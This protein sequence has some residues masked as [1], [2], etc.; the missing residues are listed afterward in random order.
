MKAV[1]FERY[2][3]PDVLELR[4]VDKPVPGDDEVLIKVV[5]TALNAM[6]WRFL[7]ADPIIIRAMNGWLTPS[8]TVPGTDVAGI[9]DAVGKNVTRFRPGDAVFGELGTRLGGMAEYAVASERALV[10]KPEGLSFVDAAAVPM[11]GLTALQGLRDVAAVQPGMKVLVL[12]A[13]GGVGTQAI[14]IA[15]LLGAEVTAVCSTSKMDQARELGADHVID[16]TKEDFSRNGQRYDVI[17]AA[18]GNRTLGDFERVLTPN[19]IFVMAGGS[20]GQMMQTVV[21]GRFKSKA[22]GKRYQSFTA[23]TDVDDLVTLGEMLTTGQ[24]SASVDRCYPLEQGQDAMRYLD[25]GHARGKIVVIV[26][27]AL[28]K[29]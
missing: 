20:T 23:R 22:N 25:A 16:Y 2:G 6:D 7:R 9:V 29:A 18:N 24:L 11:A 4:D 21:L 13:S 8:K 1:V 17:F 12:G 19:G 27:E 26:D 5:A 28:A 14:Q 15:R 3:S 10:A